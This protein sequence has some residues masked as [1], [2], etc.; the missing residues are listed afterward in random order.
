MALKLTI[1]EIGEQL[2]NTTELNLD[3]EPIPSWGDDD[4]TND[5]SEAGIVL[6]DHTIYNCKSIIED[7]PG[8]NLFLSR[9]INAI[10]LN[11]KYNIADPTKERKNVNHLFE[12][13]K[14]TA[15]EEE[16]YKKIEVSFRDVNNEEY[17]NIVFEKCFMVNYLEKGSNKE[18]TVEFYAFIRNFDE[19][20]TAT[21]ATSAMGVGDSTE[22]RG[23]ATPLGASSQNS[24]VNALVLNTPSSANYINGGGGTPQADPILVEAR[25]STYGSLDFIL[26]VTHRN[27]NAYLR[28]GGNTDTTHSVIRSEEEWVLLDDYVR[29]GQ[30]GRPRITTAG[31]EITHHY[32]RSDFVLRRQMATANP[33]HV[34]GNL[35]EST[36]NRPQGIIVHSTHAANP[37]LRRYVAPDDGILGA[38][39]A[40]HWNQSSSDDWVRGS[41]RD[42]LA[43]HAWI[44]VTRVGTVATYQTL[45]WNMQGVHAGQPANRTHIGFEICEFF[46]RGDAINENNRAYFNAIYKES[47]QLCALLCRMYGFDPMNERHLIDHWGGSLLSPQ[48]TNASNDVD[49]PITAQRSRNQAGYFYIF[50]RNMSQFRMAVRAVNDAISAQNKQILESKGLEMH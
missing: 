33:V 20:E 5:E 8:R 45:P 4:N 24:G 12:W 13:F 18:G 14:K 2:P 22:T 28:R 50:G 37:T 11:G 40:R 25:F 35:M 10:E 49:A 7:I 1:T 19:L 34:R 39:A 30:F 38:P 17:K 3:L 36:N 15:Q 6:T 32:S 16:T 44:G 21:S 41:R 42:A 43:V 26:P 27:G 23:G 31:N 48:L 9:Y 47:V 29:I 46:S